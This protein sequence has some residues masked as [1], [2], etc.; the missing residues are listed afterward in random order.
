MSSGECVE[1]MPEQERSHPESIESLRDL[2]ESTKSHERLLRSHVESTAKRM[3][4]FREDVKPFTE[5][6]DSFA[7]WVESLASPARPLASHVQRI[8]SSALARTSKLVALVAPSSQPAE[9]SHPPGAKV[10]MLR[11]SLLIVA[12]LPGRA[13]SPRGRLRVLGRVTERDTVRAILERLA[14]AA[15]APCVARARDPMDDEAIEEAD[16]R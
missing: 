8:D 16:E 10:L 15:E 4:P 14:M 9:D 2:V 13:S 7:A 3:K 11:S 1:S 6:I 5:P 12:L